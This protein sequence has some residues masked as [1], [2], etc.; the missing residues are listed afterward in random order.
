MFGLSIKPGKHVHLAIP[1]A[2]RVHCVF[3][4][5][6][7][8]EQASFGGWHG[9][10]GGFPSN[11]GKQKQTGVSLTTRHPLFSPQTFG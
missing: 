5:H 7:D 8:I 2:K 9:T 4:P 10:V 3:G 1:S 6:D 11:S